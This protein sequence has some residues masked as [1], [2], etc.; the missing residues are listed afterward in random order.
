MQD[1]YITKLGWDSRDKIFLSVDELRETSENLLGI[2]K[3]NGYREWIDLVIGNGVIY[4]KN[5]AV[6]VCYADLCLLAGLRGSRY[7]EANGKIISGLKRVYLVDINDIDIDDLAAERPLARLAEKNKLVIDQE[8]LELVDKIL[9]HYRK[10]NVREMWKVYHEL[11]RLV[12]EKNKDVKIYLGY[13]DG[14]GDDIN[15]VLLGHRPGEIR[16]GNYITGYVVIK[17]MRG[18]S[19][20]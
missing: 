11:K 4:M 13:D 6:M 3:S 14:Y 18:R 7:I 10:G 1:I 20:E 5:G 2:R 17:Y 16:F 19:N 15:M 9:S 8:M 12:H